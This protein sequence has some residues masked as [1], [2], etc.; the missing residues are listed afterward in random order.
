MTSQAV[1]PPPSI[2][3]RRN[4]FT[5]PRPRRRSRAF[6]LVEILVVIVIISILLV[7]VIPAVNSL[8][9]S[10]LGKAAVS[11][12]MNAVEQARVLAI[13]SG[14]AT[15]IVFA[16]ETL[17]STDATAPDKYRT[18]AYIVFQD[19]NFVPVAI[20]KWYFLPAGISF[21]PAASANSG[22][23]AAKD[24]ATKFS[25]PG[26]VDPTPIALPFIKFDAN[27]MVTLPTD[28]SVMFVKF[29][30]GFV[31]SSGQ[32]TFTESTQNEQWDDSPPMRPKV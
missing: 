30:S 14:A 4:A 1:K 27:G 23:L 15:Y 22:L 17:T 9:K 2:S 3:H 13:T 12:F 21:L 28:P 24:P 10:S 5:L 32:T 26:S 18:K 19:K 16:D 11:N 20:S 25:C 31:N 8:S 29:F 7:A 6:T